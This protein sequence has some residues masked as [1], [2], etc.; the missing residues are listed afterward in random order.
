MHG[1]WGP[2]LVIFS[3][4]K[5]ASGSREVVSQTTPPNPRTWGGVYPFPNLHWNPYPCPQSLQLCIRIVQIKETLQQAKHNF[6]DR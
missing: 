1:P 3:A 4:L 6:K 2:M 5:S